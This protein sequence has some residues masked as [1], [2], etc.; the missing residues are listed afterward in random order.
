MSLELSNKIYL[1]SL[2]WPILLSSNKD[3]RQRNQ[4]KERYLRTQNWKDWKAET[5]VE[6]GS[7]HTAREIN[8]T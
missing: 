3:R 2:F 7:R 8:E 6:G 5:Q 4:T 1:Y